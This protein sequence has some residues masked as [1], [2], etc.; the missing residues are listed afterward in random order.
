MVTVIHDLDESPSI[1]WEIK[2]IVDDLPNP[3]SYVL[4]LQFDY[5]ENNTL[6]Y[7]DKVEEIYFS[8]DML[9]IRQ[10]NKSHAFFDYKHI[11]EYCIINAEDVLDLGEM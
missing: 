7:L 8:A 3:D 6:F 11:L 10:K 1:G 9:N 2:E 5:R 4:S